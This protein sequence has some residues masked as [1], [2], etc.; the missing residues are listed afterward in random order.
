MLLD[1]DRDG[2]YLLLQFYLDKETKACYKFLISET[3]E[4]KWWN[5]QTRCLEGAVGNSVRVRVPPS[6]SSPR[7]P[8][9]NHPHYLLRFQS[10]FS[11]SYAFFT[12]STISFSLSF[13]LFHPFLIRPPPLRFSSPFNLQPSTFNPFLPPHSLFTFAFSYEAVYL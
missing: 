6:A 12:F 1:I 5:W 9:A 13:F 8:S 2:E 4:P 7:L 10:P 3:H 11:L